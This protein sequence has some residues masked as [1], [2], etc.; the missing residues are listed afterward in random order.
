MAKRTLESYNQHLENKVKNCGKSWLVLKQTTL[1]GSQYLLIPDRCKSNF[2]ENCRKQNLLKLRKAMFATMRKDKWRLCTLTFPDHTKNLEQAIHDSY[3]MFKRLTRQLRKLQPNI[4][5]IRSIEIHKSGFIHLHCVFNKFVPIKFIQEKWKEVGGGIADI[6]ASKRCRFC[7]KPTPC[8]HTPERKKLG[9]RDAA[10]YLTEEMEKTMQDPHKLGFIMWKNRVRTIATSRNM[11]LTEQTLPSEYIG[12]FSSLT[13]AYY[14]YEQLEYE[15]ETKKGCEPSI[16]LGNQSVTFCAG[17]HYKND[18]KKYDP[19]KAPEMHKLLRS[20][21]ESRKS[22]V[23][24]HNN[25]II[26]N[27]LWENPEKLI[28]HSPFKKYDRVTETTTG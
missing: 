6:R 22:P 28:W 18:P 8:I 3:L 16:K 2:C 24:D 9:Y 25:E 15:A 4:K 17:G 20:I 13:Q 10:R 14:L 12:K 7:H 11:K 5:Y 19:K 23:L 21:D 27:V 26:S 1:L